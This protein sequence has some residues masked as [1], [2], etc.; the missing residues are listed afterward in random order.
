MAEAEKALLDLLYLHPT[1]VQRE[2]FS[3]LRLERDQAKKLLR[4][5]KLLSWS[6]RFPRGRMRERTVALWRFLSDA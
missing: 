6:H 1:L 4:E 3:S 2:D 5:K